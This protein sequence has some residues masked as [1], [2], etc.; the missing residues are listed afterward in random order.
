MDLIVTLYQPD[1]AG[2]FPLAIVN[3][4]ANGKK[5]KPAAMQRHRF[6]YLA[7]Y[8]LS[9][10]YAVAL[11][12]MR[13]YAGSGGAQGHYHC[14]LASLAM[15]NGRDIEGV[16]N[17]LSSDAQIDT[18]RVVVAGQ[19]FGG[20]N[21]LGLGALQP[22]DVRGLVNFVGGIETS[23]CADAQGGPSQSLVQAAGRLGSS[24]LLPELWFYGE[25]DSLFGPDVWQP[26]HDAFVAH[27]AQVQLVDVGSIMDDSHQLLSHPETIALWAPKVDAFLMR[28]GLPG[29]EVLPR[30]LPSLPPAPSH[31]AALEDVAAVPWGGAAV[32]ASYRNFLTQPLPRAF[33]ISPAGLAADVHGGFDPLARALGM[34]ARSRVD[35]V[36][37]AFDNDVVFVPPPAVAR[38][39]AT[40]FAAIDDV[41]AVPWVN[42]KGRDAYRTFL[43][44]PPPRAFVIGPAG[45]NVAVTTG[46]DPLA[47]AMAICRSAHVACRP[48]AVD[49][50][51]VWVAPPAPK[52]PAASGYAAIGD[53]AAVPWVNA[54]GRALYARFLRASL[55]RA[56]VVA[57]GG[58][59]AATQGGYDPLGRA[60]QKCTEAGLACR[61]YAVDETVVWIAPK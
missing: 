16:I 12:M 34:C 35:C 2:P 21:T 13:G 37:Y 38:P 48:Y 33:V 54:G 9:R 61:P 29:R 1:G 43:G 55:P 39:P 20:W 11:P 59:A 46:A 44:H 58:Q 50:D 24:T 52:L 5:E 25:N 60:L 30:Y 27:G 36:P 57:P 28:I 7:Y 17:G 15:D 51:V 31:F 32:Q 56:F 42:D 6:T 53:V 26:M 47:R 23:G 45:E 18:S 10:G 41:A 40:H 49:N 8:F 3:H 22:R 4:G 19:S 14:D